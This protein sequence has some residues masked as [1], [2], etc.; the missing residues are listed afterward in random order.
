M[1]RTMRSVSAR[2]VAALGVLACA[3][4]LLVGLASPAAAVA[5]PPADPATGNP[6]PGDFDGNG[7]A[8][9]VAGE[10]GRGGSAGGI[11]VLYGT[12]DG[13]TADGSGGAPDDQLLTQDT[14]SVPGESEN[15]DAFGATVAVG[16]FNDDLCADVAVGVPGENGNAGSVTVLYG[17]LGTGLSGTGSDVLDQG[18]AGVPGGSEPG[19]R[20]GA[21]L[22]AGSFN[23]TADDIA[24]LAVGG[25][26]EAIGS[27]DAEGAAW[28]LYG[29]TA[30]LGQGAGSQIL[31]QDSPG[32]P[33]VPESGDRFGAALTFGFFRGDCLAV[34]VPGEND[35]AGLVEVL[36]GDGIGGGV[37]T[38]S[39][40]TPRVPGAAEAGDLFGA[41]LAAG[42]TTAFGYDDLAVGA[43]GE[44]AE[45]GAVNVLQS[46]ESGLN[47]EF[48]ADPLFI[49]QATPGIKGE[50]VAGDEFGAAVQMG[51]LDGGNGTDLAVGV[52]GD[53]IGFGGNVGAVNVLF[54]GAGGIGPAGDL[55]FHQDVGGVG[56]AA[57][58]GD[59]FGTSL[60][61]QPIQNSG[62][63]NL[64]IGV[65]FE[66]GGAL[67]NTGL[68][69]VLA[70]NEFGPN[71]F[72]GQTWS[73][74]SPG[75]TGALI[76][77]GRL[78]RDLG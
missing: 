40:D 3:G 11:H 1:T 34:G 29:D 16:D 61:A 38:F 13:L 20:F 33:G 6:L 12:A 55:R 22:T 15:G 14:A 27:G 67:S 30:G 74:A 7:H 46:S 62:I 39:Q 19:D 21:T 36:P 59:R 71:P 54:G 73:A 4:A 68:F 41:A 43:P 75:V 32:V 70:T 77:N 17:S 72:G 65:P 9:A 25:P 60:S 23:G 10:P 56:G 69:H 18:S 52:P 78:A 28:L 58:R 50:A 2:L 44:N 24:D 5:C 45:R 66:D 63:D 49:S 8:D 31:H 35:S 42:D 64:L 51:R 26:G 53:G 37:T 48:S 57:E 76:P 47:T